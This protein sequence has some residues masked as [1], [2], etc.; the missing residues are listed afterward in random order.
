MTTF[1]QTLKT[2]HGSFK[3]SCYHSNQKDRQI[4]FHQ[5][6]ITG[7]QMK[8]TI[9]ILA[10]VLVAAMA[11]TGF[12]YAQTSNPDNVTPGL[13]WM[14]GMHNQMMGGGFAGMGVMHDTM[15]Q[16]LADKL[17]ISVRDLNQQLA[18]ENTMWQI[19]ESKGLSLDEFRSW[20]TEAHKVTI[21]KLVA[22]GKLTQQQADW[23]NS[24]MSQMIEN[25]FGPGNC[26]GYGTNITN[27]SGATTDWMG[28][29]MSGWGQNSQ[30]GGT[31]G[32]RR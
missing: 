18:E 19:A 7:V 16:A 3:V 20:M 23:M 31:M 25:G 15:V 17:G 2:L 4:T 13:G 30:T 11:T 14:Q 27:A 8:K 5:G 1:T 6:N 10:V 28:N 26:P 21:D 22:E 32:G 24:H 9:I 29:M 12:V